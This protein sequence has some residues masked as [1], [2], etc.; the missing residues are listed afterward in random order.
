MDRSDIR[1]A[2]EALKSGGLVIMPTDTVYGVAADAAVP[3]AE[4]LIYA[5]KK[6][7]AGKPI[8][9]LA[10]SVEAIRNH[11]AVL[12]DI[13]AKLA[14]RFWPGPLTMV[15]KT[16]GH[17]KRGDEGFRIPDHAQALDLLRAAGG[18]LRVTSANES[19]RPPAL[20]AGAARGALGEHVAVVL[21]AGPAPGGTASTVVRVEE[22]KAAGEPE[23]VVLREGAV[24]IEELEGIAPV[25]KTE[26]QTGS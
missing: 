18:V 7:E 3:G 20:T 19:G 8:P 15:L 26:C 14:A 11:G 12:G 1:R 23:I 21:D 22:R 25:R 10:A 24:S 6:R 16:A 17:G 5:A 4:A 2:V 13:E 9:L